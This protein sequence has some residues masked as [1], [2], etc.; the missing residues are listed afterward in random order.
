MQ[1]TAIR[2]PSSGRRKYLSFFKCWSP[3]W[4]WFLTKLPGLSSW[5]FG[6]GLSHPKS[7]PHCLDTREM[8]LRDTSSDIEIHCHFQTRPGTSDKKCKN[9]ECE[10]ICVGWMDG[11]TLGYTDSEDHGDILGHCLAFHYWRC[12]IN[13][14]RQWRSVM[15]CD[16]TVTLV[17][18]TLPFF[19]CFLEKEEN[20]QLYLQHY[21]VILSFIISYLLVRLIVTISRTLTLTFMQWF[22]LHICKNAVEELLIWNS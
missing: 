2:H 12:A 5:I 1:A 18:C 10:R 22:Q 11:K 13:Q 17:P 7:L 8:S 19:F 20:T 21:I 4:P 14:M 3:L 9:P 15:A 16:I 6:H